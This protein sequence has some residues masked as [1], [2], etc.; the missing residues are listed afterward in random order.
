LRTWTWLGRIDGVK[1]GD[2]LAYK[3]Y[4][5]LVTSVEGDEVKYTYLAGG[6]LG[7]KKFKSGTTIKILSYGWVKLTPL[8][9]E[10][11]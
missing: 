6:T 5:V 9:E 10:L 7:P 3:E 8:M 4:V 1:S 11:F 2:K